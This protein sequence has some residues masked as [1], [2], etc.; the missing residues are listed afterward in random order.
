MSGFPMRPD[1]FTPEWIC[2]AAGF[3]GSRLRSFEATPIGTGQMCDSFRLTLDWADQG[4]APNTIVAKCPAADEASRNAGKAM[5]CYELEARWYQTF[6]QD[7]PIRTPHCFHVDLGEDLASFV[8][9]LEDLAPAQQGDQLGGANAEQVR[10]ALDEAAHL[11]AQFWDDA[12][13]FEKSWLRYGEGNRD[14]IRAFVPQVYPEFCNR[15]KYRLAPEVL[16]LGRDLVAR[17]DNYLR[18]R[19]GP[20]TITHNDLRLDNMLF[21]DASGRAIV[22]DWQTLGLGA[23]P[24]DAA[25]LI[26]TSFKEP[27]VR[28]SNEESLVRHYYDDLISKGVQNYA[29]K[30]CWQ[31]YKL[32]AFSGFVMA[33]IASMLVERTERGDEMFAVMAERPALQALHLGSLSLL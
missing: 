13:L 23:G 25:Y 2:E 5:H 28:A 10:L 24:V 11:H 17:W 12:S 19:E 7:A 1:E 29:W 21:S 33:M 31:T 15:Y 16:E 22:V 20:R 8:L 3:V 9:L 26:G 4:D 32:G 6:A 18:E 30:A 27:G 14:F